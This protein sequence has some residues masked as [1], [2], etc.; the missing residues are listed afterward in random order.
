MGTR[1]FCAGRAA[2]RVLPQAL[3]HVGSNAGIQ[4]PAP[5]AEHI[6]EI[7][8]SSVSAFAIAAKPG[9]SSVSPRTVGR[10]AAIFDHG[11]KRGLVKL[12]K[13]G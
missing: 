3:F 12:R 13:P 5:A 6:D 4:T 8:Y 9:I 10:K 7:H 11:G 2:G 1:V